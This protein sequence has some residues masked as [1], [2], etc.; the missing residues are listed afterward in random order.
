MLTLKPFASLRTGL[1]PGPGR[2]FQYTVLGADEPGI[3]IAEMGGHGCWQIYRWDGRG[4]TGNYK[5]AQDA[6]TALKKEIAS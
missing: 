2:V 5:T 6:L 1:V 4:W 3:S